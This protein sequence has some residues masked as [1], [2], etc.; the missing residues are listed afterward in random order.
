MAKNKRDKNV[1]VL[2]KGTVLSGHL[3]FS[4][5]LVIE[6]KFSGSIDGLGNLTVE[7]TAR[8]E[9]DFVRVHSV[10]V[11]GELTG[12]VNAVDDVELANGCK[13][14]G[15]IAASKLKIADA[16]D[17]EGNVKMLRDNISVDG[18]FFSLSSAD[19]KA[20]LGR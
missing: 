11:K 14:T 13:M 5:S 19:L 6:G 2:G 7:K 12:N 20:Q 15:N 16:V 17:F 4:D 8:C 1:T 18:D 3:K 9:T 10:L